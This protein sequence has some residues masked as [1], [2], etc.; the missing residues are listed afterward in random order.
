MLAD[1]MHRKSK[2]IDINKDIFIYWYIYAR[3]YGKILRTW[4]SKAE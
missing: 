2:Q 1:F 3:P 4:M